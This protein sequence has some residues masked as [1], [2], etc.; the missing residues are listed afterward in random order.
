MICFYGCV[1]VKVMFICLVY[2]VDGYWYFCS[3]FGEL[4]FGVLINMCFRLFVFIMFS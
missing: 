3:V 1:N 2:S 4:L